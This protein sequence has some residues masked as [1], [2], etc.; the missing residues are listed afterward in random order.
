[1][2]KT[3]TGNSTIA[4]THGYYFLHSVEIC[5]VGVKYSKKSGNGLQYISKITNDVIFAK[6]GKQSQKPE[7]LYRVIETML[8]GA[9]KVELFA[10]NHK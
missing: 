7:E 5:L 6:V 9:R 8:P 3:R 2:K 4:I 1:V 10:K